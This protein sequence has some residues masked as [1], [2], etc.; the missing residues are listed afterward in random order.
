MTT[1]NDSP[2]ADFQLRK[3]FQAL[4]GTWIES[5]YIL[6]VSIAIISLFI[7]IIPLVLV[8]IAIR[9]DSSGP[10]L[11][12]Q[13]RTGL[14]GR[15]F[16]IYKFRTM[17]VLENG[18]VI[19]QA[20]KNDPRVTRIGRW[21]RRTSI[22][23]LPQLLNVLRGE[24]SLVGPRPHAV[25]HDH[26]YEQRIPEYWERFAVKPGITG[27]AQVNGSRGETPSLADMQHRV[28]LDLWYVQHW[29]HTL[30]LRIIIKTIANE[31]ALRGRGH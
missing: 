13:T 17:S 24:M 23:E 26:Y 16:T 15:L 29:S 11:F 25:A 31:I 28:Q 22:D 9:L 2:V 30:D 3:P 7:L 14:R 4:G 19:Q 21:L 10:V 6:D 1:H 20:K 27:W 8:A 18:L 5:K 12:K